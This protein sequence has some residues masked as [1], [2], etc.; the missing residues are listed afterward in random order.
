MPSARR[1]PSTQS[2]VIPNDPTG[3]SKQQDNRGCRKQYHETAISRKCF[4]SKR[5]KML[6]ARKGFELHQTS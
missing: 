1:L 3:R 6:N 5:T 4:G 2:V